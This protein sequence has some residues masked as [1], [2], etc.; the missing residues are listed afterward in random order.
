MKII[1]SIISN[2]IYPYTFSQPLDK[3]AFFDIETTGLSPN[4]SSLYLLGLMR[5]DRKQN[6]WMLCQ[7]FADNYQ[8]EKKIIQNFLEALADI[9]FLYHFNGQTFDIPYLLKKCSRH[10]IAPSA[11]CNKLLQDKS[12]THS[13]DL[14]KKIR[15]LRH[16]LSLES[17][18]QTE[19]E[20]F[21]HLKRTDSFSGAELI[22]VYSEYMQQ[23]ILSPDNA[24]KLEQVL[25]LHNHDDIEMMLNLCSLLTYGEY[26]SD[27]GAG[28]L[29]QQEIQKT[30][31][32]E[33]ENTRQLTV[34]I[35]LPAAVPKEI[36]IYACYPHNDI[37]ETEENKT[38]CLLPKASLTFQ[39][40]TAILK[41]PLYHGTLKFFFPDY[42]NYY[43]LPVE[44]TAIH[45]SVSAF[46]DHA[47]RKKATAATCY[48]K[49]EGTFLPDLCMPKKTTQETSENSFPVFFRQY[50]DKL[51]FYE[52][53]KELLSN[54]GFWA[55][56]LKNQLPCF[57][58]QFPNTP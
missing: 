40:E 11:H 8:S 9:E 20:R 56:Y 10:A 47:Y 21:L 35:T 41:I 16:A 6:H 51:P 53:T 28:F 13:I 32:T 19:C 24:E 31:K 3:I 50:K 18:K 12:G 44:D 33:Q 43:Y 14:L 7:W 48:T 37:A 46:V 30:L 52:L 26:L 22:T 25:L 58:K 27:A 15:P 38:G 39:K 57:K 49:K 34:T 42:K 17:C 4:A 2:P 54:H 36:T 55:E 45:K 5:F 1:N 23:K 29:F